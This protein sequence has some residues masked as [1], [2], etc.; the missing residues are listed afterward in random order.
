M[1]LEDVE[2]MVE[3]TKIKEP[4]EENAEKNDESLL[5]FWFE[6]FHVLRRFNAREASGQTIMHGVKGCQEE[7][8]GTE[9]KKA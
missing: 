9:E 4:E 3:G 5:L 7:E 8:E 2:G 1:V 6:D